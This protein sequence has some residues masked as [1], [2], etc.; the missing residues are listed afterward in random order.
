MKLALYNAFD[1][2]DSELRSAKELSI[3]LPRVILQRIVHTL[4]TSDDSL[5]ATRRE[6]DSCLIIYG[7]YSRAFYIM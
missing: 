5:L 4:A 2:S 6:N 1:E 3:K 7:I